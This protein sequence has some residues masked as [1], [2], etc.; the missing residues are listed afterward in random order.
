MWNG[1][2]TVLCWV[3]EHRQK[4]NV[5]TSWVCRVL[6]LSFDYLKKK[7]EIT[8]FNDGLYVLNLFCNGEPSAI[9]LHLQLFLKHFVFPTV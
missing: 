9:F 8:I 4:E 1:N 6:V 5:I 3:L 7:K 2:G